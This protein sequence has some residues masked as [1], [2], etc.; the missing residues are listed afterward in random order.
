MAARR[1]YPRALDILKEQ[2]ERRELE[3]G[4]TR[5]GSRGIEVWSQRE[6]TM[7]EGRATQETKRARSASSR[8]EKRK[9][10]AMEAL[11]G[12]ARGRGESTE[13]VL[14]GGPD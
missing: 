9:K 12:L 7:Y 3:L 6:D 2:E 10:Q 5:T 11:A 14:A 13:C 8:R 4:R 1:P